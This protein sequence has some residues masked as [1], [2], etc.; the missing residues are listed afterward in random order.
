MQV[1]ADAMGRCRQAPE[2]LVKTS[3]DL[4]PATFRASVEGIK[5]AVN[6][7]GIRR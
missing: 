1:I 2:G 4:E 5:D 7:L 3:G 6:D